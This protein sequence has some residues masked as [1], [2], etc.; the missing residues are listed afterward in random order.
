MLTPEMTESIK[1][2]E[3]TS[4]QRMQCEPARM[5]A[6]EKDALLKQYHPDYREKGFTEIAVGP[7]RG[8]K[9]PAELGALLHAD[10]RL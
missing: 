10:R 3:E 7:N 8:Q 2:V 6:A 5:S 1:K 9:V 4:A